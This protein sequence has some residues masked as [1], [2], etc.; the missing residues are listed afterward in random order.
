MKKI[1]YFLT[2][3]FLI[4]CLTVFFLNPNNTKQVIYEILSLWL[5]KVLVVLVPF[6][7]LSNIFLSYPFVSKLIYPI[8]NKILHFE[9]RKSC[10]LLLL[11]FISGN[12]TSSYL[13]IDSVSKKEISEKEGNRLL[14]CSVL[15]SPIFTILLFGKIGYIVYFVQ[16][17]VSLLLFKGK[18]KT[19]ANF[20]LHSN[21]SSLLKIIDDCPNV[22]LQILSSM[23]FVGLFRSCILFIFSHLHLT[24]FIIIRYLLD[25]FEMTIG[26]TS[27]DS[28]L[29]SA[30]MILGLKV[31]LLS[32]GGLS[33]IIQIL[34]KLKKTNLSK[35]NLIVY[36]FIH[37]IL[38]TLLVEVIF[39]IFFQ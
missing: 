18:K 15:S 27:I 8:F 5:N 2:A 38:S 19:N 21:N 29:L 17:L 1:N 4:F 14:R 28:Y 33:I 34:V 16:I 36:R 32:F 9:N 12:P 20:E 7:L 39:L 37:A 11:C 6:Y 35:I 26:L 23:I 13:I 31:F 3:S 22:M 30:E 24:D 10:S 25:S